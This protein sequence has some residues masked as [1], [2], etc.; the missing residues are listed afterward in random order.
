MN[1]MFYIYPNDQNTFGLELQYF[2]G[3]GLLVSP[4]TEEDATSVSV[5]FPND[6]FYDFYTHAPV[7]GKGDYIEISDIDTTSIPLHYRGGVIFPQRVASG[8]TTAAVRQ[9]DFEL[10]VAL[11]SQGTASGELYLDDGLNIVQKSTTYIQFSFDGK[12]L[13]VKGQWGYNSGV[14]IDSVT[15]LGLGK[16][17]GCSVNGK[18]A[19]FQVQ[20]A[21]GDVV[22]QVGK[23]MTGDFTVSVDN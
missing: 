18:G 4:V 21:Q 20:G 10:I 8:M 3:P 19:G 23:G 9:E 12:T 14:N 7:Q 1:P 6:I 22:V 15:F 17:K 13:S 2:Y 11:N 5:Y 16:P